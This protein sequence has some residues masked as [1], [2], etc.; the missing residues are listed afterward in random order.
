[1]FTIPTVTYRR[2]LQPSTCPL[3]YGQDKLNF[4]SVE[5]PGE[6][7][8]PEPIQNL[9]NAFCN[10]R[11][12][13]NGGCSA[14][15]QQR[16]I[17]EYLGHPPEVLL[18]HV[19]RV[20]FE[21]GAMKKINRP[22]SFEE[23]ITLGKQFFDPRLKADKNIEYELSSIQ[24]HSGAGPQMGHYRI[25]AKGRSGRWTLL[26]DDQDSANGTFA[27]MAGVDAVRREAYIFAYRRLP[28]K[29]PA[30]APKKTTSAKAWQ[31]KPADKPATGGGTNKLMTVDMNA[32]QR[33]ISREKSTQPD[34]S[35]EIIIQQQAYLDKSDLEKAALVEMVKNL[36]KEKAELERKLAEKEAQLALTT[37]S[38]TAGDAS[39]P[40]KGTMALVFK[41]ADG[42]VALDLS[43]DG[44]I[45][46]LQSLPLR[47]KKGKKAG[48]SDKD[49][50]VEFTDPDKPMKSIEFD[51]PMEST[52]GKKGKQGRKSTTKSP[53]AKNPKTTK[54]VT[55]KRKIGKEAEGPGGDKRRKTG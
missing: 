37:S 50:L 45:R 30:P 44:M 4:L 24:L 34:V 35:T 28:V 36:S 16:A 54:D 27:E 47:P 31:V 33:R 21:N 53:G 1:M 39:D 40:L 11:F 18:V 46:R 14:C 17:R 20:V 7:D 2:C 12:I 15:K 8:K 43:M 3:S 23:K 51:E 22:V 19:S 38:V 6:A 42:K 29:P 10:E 48:V 55:K 26:D 5:L 52:T 13:S 32:V 9:I 49:K 25:L 41:T